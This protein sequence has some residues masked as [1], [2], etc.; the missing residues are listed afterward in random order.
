MSPGFPPIQKQ[1][2]HT[3]DHKGSWFQADHTLNHIRFQIDHGKIIE[4]NLYDHYGTIYDQSMIK[5]AGK[6]G[7]GYL[8][9][10]IS[11]PK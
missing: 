8:P 10:I 5:L 11:L 7:S 3:L 1:V 2:D 9:E 6:P 4:K